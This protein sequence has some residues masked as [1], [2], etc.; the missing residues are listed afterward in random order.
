[1]VAIRCTRTVLRSSFSR[2]NLGQMRVNKSP[3]KKIIIGSD[4]SE[5]TDAIATLGAAS[6]APR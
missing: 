4:E 1:M 2:P 6:R 5:A 3:I